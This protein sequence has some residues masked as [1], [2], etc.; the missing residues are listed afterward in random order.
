MA[1]R[2][3]RQQFKPFLFELDLARAHR[4]RAL[5]VDL[6]FFADIDGAMLIAELVIARLGL[7]QLLLQLGQA[8]VQPGQ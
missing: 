5:Q 3:A 6:S 1:G 8:L 2:V 7:F 4:R